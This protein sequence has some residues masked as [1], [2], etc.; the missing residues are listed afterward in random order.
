M[1][2]FVTSHNSRRLDTLQPITVNGH[3]RQGNHT[4]TTSSRSR[5]LRNLRT[6]RSAALLGKVL[7]YL[8][9]TQLQGTELPLVRLRL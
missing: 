1:Y 9:G 6:S 5:N 4:N 7:I 8:Y 3:G 2:N